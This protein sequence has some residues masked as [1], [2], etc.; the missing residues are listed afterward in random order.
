MLSYVEFKAKIKE[1]L[2][3]NMSP[4]LRNCNVV[5]DSKLIDGEQ[6]DFSI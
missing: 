4:A 2:L 6:R 1:E 3:N 5:L